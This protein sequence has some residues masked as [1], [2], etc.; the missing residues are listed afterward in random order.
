MPFD[1]STDDKWALERG[2]FLVGEAAAQ[3]P[4]KIRAAIDVPWTEI[5][6]LRNVLAHQYGLIEHSWLLETVETRL[7]ELVEAIKAYLSN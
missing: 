3:I 7:P 4:P 6:G 1:G 2:L 5:I